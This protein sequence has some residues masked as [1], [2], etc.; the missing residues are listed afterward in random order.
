[1][2]DVSDVDTDQNF[3]LT[4]SDPGN[5]RTCVCVLFIISSFQTK[6]VQLGILESMDGPLVDIPSQY[7]KLQ[8]VQEVVSA[9]VMVPVMRMEVVVVTVDILEK[10]VISP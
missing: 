4:I 5:E 10:H 9:M 7:W 3:N 8:V 1:M 6:V 2:T